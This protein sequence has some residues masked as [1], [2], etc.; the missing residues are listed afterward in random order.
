MRVIDSNSGKI[1]KFL[2]E[3]GV[4]DAIIPMGD[5]N[6]EGYLQLAFRDGK[7]KFWGG[8]PS[9]GPVMEF[10]HW[11]KGFPYKKF[12]KLIEKYTEPP[13][14]PETEPPAA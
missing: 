10:M 12:T 13:P 4:I 8:D 9:R 3:N 11:P 1:G 14:G 6:S 7:V 2:T 5:W